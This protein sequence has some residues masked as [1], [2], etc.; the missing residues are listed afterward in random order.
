MQHVQQ[1]Q[2]SSLQYLQQQQLMHMQQQQLDTTERPWSPSTLETTEIVSNEALHRTG[3]FEQKPLTVDRKFTPEERVLL[4]IESKTTLPDPPL[5]RA[6]SIDATTLVNYPGIHMFS[7]TVPLGP[8][9][10]G[11]AS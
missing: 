6:N 5:S 8:K 3:H 9:I 1:P 2:M 10:K 11:K 4:A 7:V